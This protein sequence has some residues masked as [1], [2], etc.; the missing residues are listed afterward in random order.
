M[1]NKFQLLI[2]TSLSEVYYLPMHVAKK[3]SSTTTKT[4]AVFDVYAK[5]SNG[6]PLTDTLLVGSTIHVNVLLHFCQHRVAL[7]TDNIKVYCAVLLSDSGKDL[8]HFV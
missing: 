6:I 1:R 4:R 3:E 7:T 2:S 8:H 5:S